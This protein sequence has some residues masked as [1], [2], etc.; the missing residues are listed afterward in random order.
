[1]CSNEMTKFIGHYKNLLMYSIFNFFF[2]WL[3]EQV[4]VKSFPDCFSGHICI[5]KISHQS[6][7]NEKMF[8]EKL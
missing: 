1:M 7:K 5:A 2:Q 6:C 3:L 4:L 8:H